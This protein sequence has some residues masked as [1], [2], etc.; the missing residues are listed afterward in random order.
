MKKILLFLLALADFMCGSSPA[1]SRFMTIFVQDQ[2][3]KVEIA[4]TPEKHAL[5]LMYRRY[6]KSDYGML[7]IFA[8]D[9]VRSFWMKNTLISLDMIFINADRQVVDLFHSVP[10]C[11]SDPCP[12]YT[13]A[14]PARYVLELS[15]GQ[16]RKLKLKVGDKIFMA[17][18]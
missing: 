6:L 15:G 13:S 17:F 5:G 7:F 12:S 9:E 2:P 4:D 16:A 8:D 10:P 1:A 11:R 14:L 18:D 3:F